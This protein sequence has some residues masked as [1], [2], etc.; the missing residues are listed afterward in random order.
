MVTPIPVKATSI[1]TQAQGKG[2]Q[3]KTP[4]LLVSLRAISNY[5]LLNFP[6]L[7]LDVGTA[8]KS[9]N[10]RHI[11]TEKLQFHFSAQGSEQTAGTMAVITPT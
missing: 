1:E 8:L 6:Q 7:L 3:K 5:L 11:K 2:K 4:F 10:Y 9:S